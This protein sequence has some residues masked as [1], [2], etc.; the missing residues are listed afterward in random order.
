MGSNLSALGQPTRIVLN[1]AHRCNMDCEWCYI[2]FGAPPPDPAVSR[3]VVAR[4]VDIGMSVI[5]FGGGDPF[6]YSFLGDLADEAKKYDLFVHV[7]TNGIGLRPIYK[8]YRLVETQIDLLA[9]PLDGPDAVTHGAMRASP[10]HFGILMERL[11]WL[12]PFRHKTKINTIVTAQNVAVLADIARLVG[13]IAPTRWSVYQYWPLSIG[14]ASEAKHGLS[15][16]AF[17]AAT[18][19]LT[20]VA[21]LA[22]VHVEVNPRSSRR[23]TYPFV[24]HDGMLYLHA[25][26]SL[27]EYQVLGSIFDDEVVD[28]LFRRCRPERNIATSRYAKKIYP[29]N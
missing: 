29:G 26:D 24:G 8:N 19:D 21:D 11:E 7:D 17:Q 28:E 16:A 20:S 12:L 10:Q 5:T 2:P 9:L 3:R 1:F 15:D 18:T 14:A 22:S 25:T 6:I 27:R 4:R 13:A 23:L